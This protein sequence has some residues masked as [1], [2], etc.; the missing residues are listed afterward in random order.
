MSPVD[1]KITLLDIALFHHQIHAQNVNFR[2]VNVDVLPG[3]S[4]VDISLSI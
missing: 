1:F 4:N 2:A 3:T